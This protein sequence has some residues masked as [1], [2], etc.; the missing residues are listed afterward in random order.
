LFQGKFV[1]S[2]WGELAEEV[3]EQKFTHI[4]TL[5]SLL[6]GH[7]ILDKVFEDM[8]LCST[9][10]TKIFIW[11]YAR[12]APDIGNANIHLKLPYAIAT[13]KKVLSAIDNSRLK[14][15]DFEDFTRFILPGF[16]IISEESA[17]RDPKMEILKFELVR[18][19]FQEGKLAYIIYFCELK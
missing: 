19:A 4:I 3:K 16:K 17:K 15:T 7:Q 1:Y 6:Y 12:T 8:A 9:S 14:L 5:G 2:A 13:K 10:E 11:D 18:E